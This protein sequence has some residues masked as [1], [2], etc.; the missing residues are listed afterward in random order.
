MAA[1]TGSSFL[2]SSFGFSNGNQFD[3]GEKNTP[4]AGWVHLPTITKLSFIKMP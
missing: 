3:V 4:L 1:Q 2:N